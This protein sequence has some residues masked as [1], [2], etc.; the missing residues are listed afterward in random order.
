MA[1]PHNCCYPKDVTPEW[2]TDVLVHAGIEATVSDFSMANIGTGQVGQNVRFD[3]IYSQ[4]QG[5]NSLVGK[6]ASDDP[7]SRQTGIAVNDYLKEVLFYQQLSSKLDVTMPKIYFS[8]INL[9]QPDEFVLMMQDLTP[10]VQGDQLAGCDADQA[11]LALNELAGLAGPLW[12][13]KSLKSLEWLAPPPINDNPS[14]LWDMLAPG[15]IERY[16][17]RLAQEHLSLLE[18]FGQKF[19]AYSA[20]DTEIFTLVHIDYRLDNMMFGGPYPV[21][22]V[23]WSPSIGSGAD[24]AAYFMGTGMDAEPRQQHERHL[25]KEYHDRLV[26]YG[27]DNYDF[28][29][30]W[31]DYRRRSF[32]G[33]V[34]AVIASMIVGQ[35]ERGDTMFM[36]MLRR[37]ADMAIELE[38]LSAL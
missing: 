24:D 2:L 3:L 29:A 15:F 37:S 34:M 9:E 25:L 6:F 17:P 16:E 14:A 22:I 5:P 31:L 35:T 27:I 4:G 36:T 7:V 13:D 12:C 26:A 30:C 11:N 1:N 38:G 21:A 18:K 8:A 10:A 23:D 33:M 32:A 19:A 28:N 20:N